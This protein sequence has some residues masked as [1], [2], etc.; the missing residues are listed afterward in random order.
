LQFLIGD[1]LQTFLCGRIE[2]DL[3]LIPEILPEE[4]GERWQAAVR[5][6]DGFPG[7]HNKRNFFSL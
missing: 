6:V 7:E 1:N 5:S 4:G 3:E 2:I